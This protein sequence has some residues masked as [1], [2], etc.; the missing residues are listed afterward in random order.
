MTRSTGAGLPETMLERLWERSADAVGF[1]KAIANENRLLILCILSE[2]EYSVSE[3]EEILKIRQPSL[4]QQLARLRADGLVTTRRDGKVI[5]YCLQSDKA[6]EFMDLIYKHFCKN[7]K[8]DP[9]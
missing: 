4:S 9:K 1:L 5:Y 6:Q 7:T 3:L 8:N 2:G